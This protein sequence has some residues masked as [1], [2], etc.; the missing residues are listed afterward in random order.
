MSERKKITPPD[1]KKRKE[2]KK[3]ISMLT[4][5]DFPIASLLDKIGVDTILVGDSLGMVVL[6]YDSTVPVTMDEMIHHC[7][8]V[9]RGIEYAFL[10]GDMP[11]M[12]YQVSSE[13]ALQNAGR[14][15]K[16]GGCDA[17]KLEGGLEMVETVNSITSVG[18]PVVGHIGLTPQTAASLGGFK[19]QGK[20][21]A[22]AKYLIDSAYALED[23]GACMIVFECIPDSLAKL[24]TEQISIPTIGIGAGPDCDGQVLVINDLIGLY[25]RLTPRF[26][27]QYANLYPLIEEAVANYIKDIDSGSFPT[28]EHSFEIDEE[29]INSLKN[30]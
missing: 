18:I 15:L 13:H 26:V 5:Y 6:G 30:N 27:K 10:I 12:S 2:L 11:F 20:D 22:S 28:K 8:A 9:K 19:V 17:V 23:A 21:V 24:I 16:E 4:A 7:S 25:P 14:F 1:L 3:K 29:I